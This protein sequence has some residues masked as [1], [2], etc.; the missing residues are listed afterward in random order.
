VSPAP[1]LLPSSLDV[2][3]FKLSRACSL[4]EIYSG[5]ESLLPGDNSKKKM[6]FDY[7]KPIIEK[8]LPK[9]MSFLCIHND[10]IK[11]MA[12]TKTTIINMWSI[13]LDKY[14]VI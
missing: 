8:R 4:F 10:P 9:T 1:S 2:K 14:M 7:P 5:G 6:S 12:P 13:N 3:F 11:S